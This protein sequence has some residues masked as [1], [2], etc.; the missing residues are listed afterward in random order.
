MNKETHLRQKEPKKIKPQRNRILLKRRQRIIQALEDVKE[1]YLTVAATIKQFWNFFF[2]SWLLKL[3]GTSHWTVCT[4]SPSCHRLIC[5]NLFSPS[6]YMRS[7]AVILYR[8]TIFK[9]TVQI[10]KKEVRITWAVHSMAYWMRLQT[11]QVTTIFFYIIYQLR[12]V[13]Q[14]SI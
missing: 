12:N 3:H 6:S 2:H 8:V 7:N 13:V 5:S 14:V 11:P 10:A 9:N 4:W 1:D